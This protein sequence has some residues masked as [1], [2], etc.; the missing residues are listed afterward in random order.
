M[1]DNPMHAG[2][3][4]ARTA[5][6]STLRQQPQPLFDSDGMRILEEPFLHIISLRK[7]RRQLD[8]SVVNNWLSSIG[9]GLPQASNAL[10]GDAQLGCC[11]LEPNAW[12]VTAVA[13]VVMRAAEAGL[14]A[15]TISDRLA[16][17]RLS[18]PLAV[19][20][21]AAGCDP[22]IVKNGACARTR[23]SSFATI[24]IQQWGEQDYRLLV[25][26]SV[27]K[28]FAGW[29]LDTSRTGTW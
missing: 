8:N 1:L 23:F 2:N 22:A 5:L 18:G 29:L 20:V 13:P 7:S 28:S 9:V 3:L 6:G 16:V 21:L 17:F 24:L 26:V 4:E 14:L 12:L 19:Q 15:T 10:S 25:D 11:W 27:A